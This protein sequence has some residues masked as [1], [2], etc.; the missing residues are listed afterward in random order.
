MTDQ[1]EGKTLE[2]GCLCGAIRYR[3]DGPP[4]RTT[5]CH[6]LHCRGSSGAAFVTWVECQSSD[7]TLLSGSPCRYESRP[8]VTRQF[9]GRCGTPLTYQRAY[10]PEEI[11]VTACSLDNPEAVLPADHLWCDRMLPWVKISDGLPRHKLGRS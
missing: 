9:C 4:R 10:E 2:G 6:C 3:I 11:D 5:H 1:Q 8:Q 7:F